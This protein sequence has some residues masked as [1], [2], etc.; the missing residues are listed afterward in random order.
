MSAAGQC[1]DTST[2]YW[3]KL[4]EEGLPERQAVYSGFGSEVARKNK[5]I[6]T[7]S[8]YQA[9]FVICRVWKAHKLRQTIDIRIF[10]KQLKQ[11]QAKKSKFK[12]SSPVNVSVKEE[13]T[14]VFDDSPAYL[15][16]ID[17]K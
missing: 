4:P 2:N 15:S 12:I 16:E 9:Y 5:I 13:T 1:I 3:R 17:S 14:G 7:R 10:R 8:E 11:S 6:C